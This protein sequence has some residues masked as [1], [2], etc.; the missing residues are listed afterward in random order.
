MPTPKITTADF[1][2]QSGVDAIIEKLRAD[3]KSK[4]KEFII[5]DVTDAAGHQYVD[6][7]QEGGGVLGIALVGYTYVLEKMGIRFFSMA[8]TSAGSINAM[9]LACAGNKE[10]EKSC[11]IIDHLVQ[12]DMF[13]FVDGKTGNNAF[14]RWIKRFISGMLMGSNPLKKIFNLVKWTI[15]SLL[16]LTVLC[17]VF[18]FFLPGIA[19]WIGLGAGIAL[20]LFIFIVLLAMNRF[21]RFVKNGFGLNEGKVFHNWINGV[22]SSFHVQ[23]DPTK[24]KIKNFADFSYH[25]MRIPAG[26]QVKKDERRKNN[27]APA[28]PLLTLITCDI[29]SERKIEFT[30][31]WDLYW[32]KEEDVHPGDFVR[33]SMS[34]PVFFETYTL[35]D[36]KKKSSFATWDK[37]LNWQNEKKDI[38]DTVQFIDGGTL[39]NF[40]INVFYNPNYP[41]PRMPTFGIRLQ[42][43]ILDSGKR[44]NTSFSGYIASLFATIRFNFDR[45]FITKNRAFSRGVKNIDVQE[46]NWLNFFME[47]KEK[48]ELFKKGAQ[49]AADFLAEFDW[50]VYKNEREKNHD[51][52]QETFDDPNN[53]KISPYSLPL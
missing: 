13:S 33:A 3:L 18:N 46:H 2:Q 47:N 12:L 48:I 50:E 1:L 40:P 17:F 8:G 42:D 23:A 35:T 45:D 44:N 15:I 16:S 49:A 41:V 9:L 4:D 25:F 22:I 36:I 27:D 39:S 32:A 37:H 14:N 7:V 52:R 24:E 34:I 20:L 26:L 5:S 6:L 29:I 19:K 10:D 21:K 38:P 51:L 31:M 53:M 43:G 28:M 30:Q 11:V